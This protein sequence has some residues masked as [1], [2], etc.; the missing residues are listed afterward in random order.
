MFA[1]L[2]GLLGSA[3]SAVGTIAA[4]NAQAAAAKYEQK[5]DIINASQEQAVAQRKA[6]GERI[7]TA[8]F[9]SSQQAAAGLSGGTSAD[10]STLNLMGAAQQ[11]GKIREMSTLYEGAEKSR[12]WLTQAQADE[13]KAQNARQAGMLG[14]AGTIVGGLGGA[15][16]SWSTAYG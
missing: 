11:E 12:Q 10:P 15:A 1:P 4:G 2:I 5:Q 9:V 3:V 14:A 7:R 8:R 16:K 13:L 6:E